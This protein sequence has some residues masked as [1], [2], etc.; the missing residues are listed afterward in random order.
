MKTANKQESE[1]TQYEDVRGS[2]RGGLQCSS[3]D[4]AVGLSRLVQEPNNCGKVVI[5][6][7]VELQASVTSSQ[8]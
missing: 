7:H 1:N 8:L 6:E 2:A 3:I 5:S 4:A